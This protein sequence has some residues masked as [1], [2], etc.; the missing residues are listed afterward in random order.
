V[1][2]DP[3]NY[4]QCDEM[5]ENTTYQYFLSR[6]NN[7]LCLN[8]AGSYTYF[9]SEEALFLSDA[10][11]NTTSFRPFGNYNQTPIFSP[12]QNVIFMVYE[13]IVETAESTASP[14]SSFALS[15][16]LIAEILLLAMVWILF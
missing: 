1:L 14:R 7:T 8:G 6:V 12:A 13:K 4:F 10:S 5:A 9:Q 15:L 11:S 3:K 2:S 16:P